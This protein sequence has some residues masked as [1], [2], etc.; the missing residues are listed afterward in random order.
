M[1]STCG[2][3]LMVMVAALVMTAAAPFA[4]AE[5]MDA[6]IHT[7]VIEKLEQAL[8]ARE[9]EHVSLRPVRARLADLYSDRARLRAM[10]ESEENCNGCRGSAK[11]RKRALQLYD[12]VLNEAAKEN[13]GALMLQMAQLN[14]LETNFKKSE[15][16]YSRIVDEGRA[17][18]SAEVLAEGLIG[19][20]EARFHRA[21]FDRA[22]ADFT[23]ALR[24]VGPGRQGPIMHR[25]AWCHLNKGE[26]VAAVHTLIKILET[27][28]LLVRPSS[29][30]VAHDNA[31]QEDIARDL[32][33]FF[34]RGTVTNREIALL[35]SLTPDDARKDTMKHFA[36]ECD[37]LGQKPAAIQAWLTLAEYEDKS[38]DRL[39]AMVRVAQ[40]RLELGQKK[41]ALQGMRESITYWQTNG[42][43]DAE[44]C[45][46]LG[47]RLR[48][49]VISWNKAEKKAPSNLLV[50][51][52]LVYLSKFG[53]DMEMTQW[54]ADAA[55]AQ[56]RYATAATLYHKSAL[57]SSKSKAKN[58]K[59]VLEAGLVGEVEMAELS[60]D[61]RTREASYN[62]YLEMN[63]NGA[64]AHKIRYQ[65]ARVAYERG[66]MNEASARFHDFA[67]SQA[68]R[69]KSSKELELCLQAADLDLDALVGLRSHALVQARGTEY[70][71]VF[72]SRQ[73]EYSK[74]TRTA[75]L[76]QAEGLEA[77][78]AIA[79]LAEV[80]LRGA[81]TEERVRFLK[82]WLSLAERSRDL[83]AVRVACRE[84]LATKGLSAADHEMALGKTAWAAEMALD[85]N[86]AFNV[87]K[88]MKLANLTRDERAM[89]LALL[90]ELAGRDS[91]PYEE[92]FLRTSRDNGKKLLVRAKM[93]RSSQRPQAEFAKHESALRASPALYASLALEVYARTGS[94]ALAERALKVRGV[95]REPA[96]RVLAR[97]LFLR[98]F[99]GAGQKLS[100]HRMSSSSERL[101]Q[102][103]L[104]ERLALLGKSER[105]A[106]RAIGM[107]DWSLQILVLTSLSRE[108]KRIYSDIVSL[109]VPR[110]LRGTDREK[111]VNLLEMNA[112]G[113]KTKHEQI[114]KK[115]ALLWGE[116]ESQNA[117]ENDYRTASVAVRPLIGRQL[118][119]LV[120]V[121]PGGIRRQIEEELN[122]TKQVP[123]EQQVA[124]A[125]KEA[126]ERPFSP[127]SLA[128]LR[129]LEIVRGRETMVAYLDARLLKLKTGEKR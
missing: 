49:L 76:K 44:L 77:Q 7:V 4:R 105:V 12:L 11:D 102:K 23:A 121:A 94:T 22:Q 87:T 45:N 15:T 108:N 80:D 26:Q 88:Q 83:V 19:R 82:T 100:S 93:V 46:A 14:E 123:S 32:A 34:A 125:R 18:H 2:H 98:E 39:E 96:G 61:N 119:R 5:K 85:F 74:I 25:I 59:Q 54:A 52:Y 79:K 63:P 30:G 90:A 129:E 109:P 103:S 65:R 57:L 50:D 72:P 27:P 33:T 29:E 95:A 118:R 6:E 48:N 128:K 71:R 8:R 21:D 62:H 17:R 60:K 9:D 40:I 81:T 112:R 73:I 47:S 3:N 70:A 86:E 43:D 10:V 67:T 124:V 58:A 64:I 127:Q 110:K 51:A 116:G 41:E 120:S 113:Y 20:A 78:A 37:R 114:E 55:R 104:T 101:V 99:A 126:K 16:L 38:S 42:C 24:L 115:L 13:R 35:E 75:V 92:E 28:E 91:R 89:K 66:E 106:N 111:Y 84:L 56:K 97:E 36:G 69:M 122:T 53:D 107:R 31:F 117:L 1:K 68:C